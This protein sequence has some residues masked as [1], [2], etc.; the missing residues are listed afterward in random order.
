MPGDR[1]VVTPLY[2][3]GPAG[4]G[5][6]IKYLRE[7]RGVNRYGLAKALGLKKSGWSLIKRWETNMGHPS[8]WYL[9]ELARFFG[10]SLDDLCDFHPGEKDE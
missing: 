10:M 6:R 2:M 1:P 3:S 8:Y 9:L 7:Q 4:L 5:S